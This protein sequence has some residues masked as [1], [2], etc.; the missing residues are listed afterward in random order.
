[1]CRGPSLLLSPQRGEGAK[2]T[3]PINNKAHNKLDLQSPNKAL[4]PTVVRQSNFTSTKENPT[5]TEIELNGLLK[6]FV[7]RQAKAA[8][9]QQVTRPTANTFSPAPVVAASPLAGVGIGSDA[10]L[11]FIYF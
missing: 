9:R 2:A 7:V 8:K 10:G 3:R 11:L 5:R 6:R 4:I 1:V